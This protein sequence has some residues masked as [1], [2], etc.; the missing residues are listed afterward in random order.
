MAD[1]QEQRN[2]EVVK[3]R[4]A[5]LQH[6]TTLSGAATLIILAIM[7][8]TE[9]PQVVRALAFVLSI[10]GLAAL[11]SLQG[12]MYL[13]NAPERTDR[14][15]RG[16]AGR[17]STWIAGSTFGAGVGTVMLISFRVPLVPALFVIWPVLVAIWLPLGIGFLRDRKKSRSNEPGANGEDQDPD[18]TPR[19]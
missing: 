10:F 19:P 14:R 16:S 17:L 5:F 18:A 12:M 1:D 3:L 6:M 7:Q 4:I 2:L 8:R 13:I 11:V 9:D 15:L